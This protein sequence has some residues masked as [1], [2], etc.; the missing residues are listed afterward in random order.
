MDVN[1]KIKVRRKELGLSDT[2]VAY[3]VGLS[4]YEYGD[5][6]QHAHEI[7]RV[8][9]LRRVKEICQLLNYDFFELFDMKC[10]FCEEG[11]KY[12]EDYSLLRNELIHKRRMETGLSAEELGDRIGFEGTAVNEMEK[13]SE[14]L[15]KWPIDYIKDLSDVINVPLQVLLNVKC[16]KCGR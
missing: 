3:K 2:E 10:F 1:K 14:F 9:E 13:D 7:F 16:K 4:I 15:E 8:T 5:V 11:K 12:L 6:E